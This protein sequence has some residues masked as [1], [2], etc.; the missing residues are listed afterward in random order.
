ML[1]KYKLAYSNLLGGKGMLTGQRIL[2]VGRENAW[3]T[4]EKASKGGKNKEKVTK[5]NLKAKEKEKETKGWSH[6][7]KT[8][9]AKG[10]GRAKKKAA[11]EKQVKQRIAKN[12]KKGWAKEHDFKIDRARPGTGL[13]KRWRANFFWR[14]HSGRQSRGECNCCQRWRPAV[15]VHTCY[16]NWCGWLNHTLIGHRHC[17][18]HRRYRMRSKV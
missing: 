10:S 2:L 13:H 8:K 16:R 4:Q 3:K 14:R 7:D 9:K 5:G 11:A 12:A 15:L 17:S 1:K 18:S 6:E